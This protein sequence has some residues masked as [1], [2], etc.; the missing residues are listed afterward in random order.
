MEQHGA[1]AVSDSD[2]LRM[3][4][5]ESAASYDLAELAQA[6]PAT[7][8]A[9]GLRAKAAAKLAAAVELGR[10]ASIAPQP[11]R[12]SFRDPRSAAD[13]L[14]GRIGHLDHEVFEVV[15]LNIRLQVI[16]TVRVAEGTGWACA[17]HPRDALKPAI[18]EGAAAVLFTHNHPSGDPSPS[19]DDIELTRRLI[20][21]CDLLGIRAVDHIVVCRDGYASIRERS[22][23]EWK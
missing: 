6:T 22:D 1:G 14:R 2:L 4:V 5:G 20:Q 23:C 8:R 15:L 10:R 7:L 13:Y 18:L 9:K 12:L 3:V 16:R 17:V 19:P 21:A 11:D